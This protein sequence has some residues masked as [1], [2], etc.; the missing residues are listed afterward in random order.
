MGTTGEEFL[1]DVAV[2][3]DVPDF[4][5][6]G[7]TGHFVWNEST[8]HLELVRVM[9]TA[10]TPPPPHAGSSHLY[11]TGN[12]RIQRAR[13]DGTQVT[14]LL[15]G[16]HGPSSYSQ[17]ALDVAAGTMYWTNHHGIHRA[18]LDGS[19]FET[20]VAGEDIDFFALAPHRKKMYWANH[21]GIWWA[22]LDGSQVALFHPPDP[23]VPFTDPLA[24]VIDHASDTLYWA[25]EA[26]SLHRI[27]LNGTAHTILFADTQDRFEA[28]VFALDTEKGKVYWI[29]R[30]LYRANLD[31]GS[32][33]ER[34]VPNVGDSVGLVLDLDAG[35]M[36]WTVVVAAS[37]FDEG[38]YRA[39]LDGSDVEA[40]VTG[41]ELGGLVLV[42]GRR[43]E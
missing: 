1:E 41:V 3:I 36:Y 7:E 24:V 6:P 17:L 26:D 43:G 31:D 34:L 4:P 30:H 12:G 2:S 22:N 18:P 20:L 19:H 38:L 37:G 13:L 35:K 29:E 39:N 9:P 21:H 15:I 32:H 33:V 25:D 16:E 27:N 8:Q 14:S 42:Q 11:W 23:L 28:E 40:L 10:R 5:A